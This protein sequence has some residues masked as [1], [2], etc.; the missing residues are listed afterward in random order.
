MRKNRIK[1][2]ELDSHIALAYLKQQEPKKPPGSSAT[3]VPCLRC[4]QDLFEDALVRCLP[5]RV[6]R[7]QQELE[8]GESVLLRA[9]PW[10]RK[11]RLPWVLLP[12]YQMLG[13]VEARLG[14]KTAA[15]HLNRPSGL[16]KPCGRKSLQ[17][18]CASPTSGQARGL[19]SFG[20]P[21]VFSKGT[22]AECATHFNTPNAHVRA[23]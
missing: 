7:R 16:W 21:W 2:A 8:A 9:R 15:G 6:P 11:V 20:L 3:R 1:S 10:I 23:L 18:I 17:K 22:G 12:Y 4:T 5:G 19:R 13:K 14:R